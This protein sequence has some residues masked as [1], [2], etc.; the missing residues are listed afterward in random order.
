MVGEGCSGV[1]DIGNAFCKRNVNLVKGNHAIP[2]KPSPF[3]NENPS[4][5]G[6]ELTGIDVVDTIT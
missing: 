3:E 6:S 2:K 4:D 5:Q 1:Y